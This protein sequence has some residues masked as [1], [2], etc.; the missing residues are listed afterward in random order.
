[1]SMENAMKFV[2][3]MSED[4][5]FRSRVVNFRQDK[6]RKA[7]EEFLCD[8]KLDFTLDELQAVRAFVLKQATKMND[9]PLK[10]GGDPCTFDCFVDC[11]SGCQPVQ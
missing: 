3:K 9:G 5:E 1:M 11:G 10:R 6:M 8:E 7:C 2:E 4:K